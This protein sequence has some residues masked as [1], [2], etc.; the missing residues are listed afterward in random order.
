MLTQDTLVW[1][2]G[3]QNWTAARNV[4]ALDPLFAGTGMIT[5]NDEANTDYDFVIDN[6]KRGGGGSGN[7]A[8]SIGVGGI[9]SGGF[10]SPIEN[11]PIG[12]DPA[13]FSLTYGGTL[14]LDFTYAE[15][16]GAFQIGTIDNL[17]SSLAGTNLL[18]VITV[19]AG[20]LLKLPISLSDKVKIFPLAGGEYEMYL[21]ALKNG[22]QAV[23]R[24]IDDLTNT[25]ATAALGAIWLRAGVGF[26]FFFTEKLFLRP[27]ILYG[28]RFINAN[29][30]YLVSR[31]TNYDGY[32]N[33]GGSV[34]ICFGIKF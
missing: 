19:N 11:P 28:Y 24:I 22:S 12:A 33:H 20:L 17:D 34:K 13:R 25:D 23:L 21:S 1:Y 27:E 9:V 4:R 26:D 6:K 16:F 10:S 2:Q 7:F 3:L 29:E 14:F 5:S 8:F 32:F 30:E 18:E 15:I 31:S